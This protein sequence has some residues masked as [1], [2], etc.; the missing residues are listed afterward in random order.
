MDNEDN[1]R[2]LQQY[3]GYAVWFSEWRTLS[4]RAL[5][6]LLQSGEHSAEYLDSRVSAF[7]DSLAAK[8]AA[9][10]PDS[11]AS[12]VEEL[13][14]ARLEKPKR[15]RQQAAREW[16]EIEDGMLV[17][18]RQAAEVAELRRLTPANLADFLQEAVVDA[19]AR[20]KLCIRICGHASGSGAVS[21]GPGSWEL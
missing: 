13:A 14:K 11:F 9:L 21:N 12:R 8:L 18:D 10:G 1:G 6:F 2:F 3:I 19:A 5:A 20:R 15:L 17:F 4:V 16:R 7:V